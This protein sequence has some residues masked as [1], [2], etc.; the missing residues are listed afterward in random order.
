MYERVDMTNTAIPEHIITPD[1]IRRT[2]VY[3]A[4]EQQRADWEA[5][6][7]AAWEVIERMKL[8]LQAADRADKRIAAMQVLLD[9]G[10]AA[11]GRAH[12]AYT[13][14]EAAHE[15]RGQA[16]RRRRT[17]IAG[18]EEHKRVAKKFARWVGGI[19]SAPGIGIERP[20]MEM[21][22]DRIDSVMAGVWPPE[23][24]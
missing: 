5:H 19:L 11:M 12:H 22:Y 3:L 7:R 14:L 9:R 21:I 24:G 6:A 10:N 20:M 23:N 18:L 4:L 1:R 2:D 15:K 13:I 16:F 17:L 8:E